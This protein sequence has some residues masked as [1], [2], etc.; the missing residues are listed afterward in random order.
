MKRIRILNEATPTTPHLIRINCKLETV[1][2]EGKPVKVKFLGYS[3]G[4][5]DLKGY[6]I[7]LPVVYDIATMKVKNKI[8][9]KSEHEKTIGHTTVFLI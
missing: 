5:V 1:A 3:G 8:K 2:E 9:L 4:S 6:N 7:P